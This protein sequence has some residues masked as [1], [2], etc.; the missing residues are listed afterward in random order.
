MINYTSLA[1]LLIGSICF[2][3][4]IPNNYKTMQEQ[5]VSLGDDGTVNEE[6]MQGSSYLNGNFQLG[7]IV[8][9]ESNKQSAYLRYNTLKD[10]VE[11]KAKPEQDEIFILPR[12]EEYSYEFKEYTLVLKDYITDEGEVLNGYVMQ[13]F[14]KGNIVLLGKSTAKIIPGSIAETSYGKDMP[15]KIKV[16]THYFIGLDGDPV[17][18]VKL[19]KRNFKKIFNEPEMKGYFSENRIKDLNDVI[20]MLEF[21]NDKV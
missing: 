18:S 1:F 7:E 16:F 10:V 9:G 5:L 11:I 21:Y 2:S 13:Y 4:N 8:I 12:S 17:I 20:D 19:K 3:Q 6:E 15:A 14:D